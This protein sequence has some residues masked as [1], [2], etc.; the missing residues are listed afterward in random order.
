MRQGLAA[1]VTGSL[2]IDRLLV[3]VVLQWEILAPHGRIVDFFRQFDGA[4]EP[5]SGFLFTL[6]DIDEERAHAKCCQRRK[7]DRDYQ[8]FVHSY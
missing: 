3:I 5:R 2:L 4:K 8:S 1:S 7:Y 6:E